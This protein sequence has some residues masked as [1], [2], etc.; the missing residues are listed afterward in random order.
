MA[1]LAVL[2]LFTVGLW[3]RTT[4]VLA[5]AIV[6][7]TAGR[8]PVIVFGFDQAASMLAFYLAV[9]GSSGQAVSIDRFIHRWRTH[10]AEF[11][12][13]R[14]GRP[15]ASTARSATGPPS[16]AS[17]ANL[18]LRLIQLHLCVIYGMAGLAK[19]QQP[20]WWEG[21]RRPAA[22]SATPSSGRST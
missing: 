16:R 5:W 14:R 7:S 17:S 15:A 21:W 3:S 13:R 10:R 4:A 9:T 8:S 20:I 12:A 1:C 22:S 18:C 19:L 11:A 6:V 2:L